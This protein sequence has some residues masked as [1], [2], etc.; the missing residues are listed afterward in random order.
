MF[1]SHSTDNLPLLASI[2][3]VEFRREQ[4]ATAL[5]RQAG[6]TRSASFQVLSSFI[7]AKYPTQ[8]PDSSA[9]I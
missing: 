7:Q 1:V 3:A 4:A 2:Q 9:H 8:I 5:S 6:A